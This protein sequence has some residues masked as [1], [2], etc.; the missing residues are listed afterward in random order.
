MS[1]KAPVEMAI[2]TSTVKP[3][4]YIEDF[5]PSIEYRFGDDAVVFQDDTISG[6]ASYLNDTA[7][8]HSVR[9]EIY[10][11]NEKFEP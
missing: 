1:G 6:N 11:G 7:S 5:F 3:Q 8:K 10:G 2:V 4:V 9:L